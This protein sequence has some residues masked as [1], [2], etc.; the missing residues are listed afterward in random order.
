[1]L[2]LLIAAGL[3]AWGIGI[4]HR[5]YDHD[6]VQRAHS[7]WLASRGLRPYTE[8]FEVHPPYFV[9]LAPILRTW[10][11]PCEAMLALRLFAAAGNLAFLAGLVA[12]GR[13]ATH[14][15]RGDRWAWLGVASVA[16]H[17]R[18][19]DFLVEFRIDGWG[20]ALAAW[21]LVHFLRRPMARYR[22]ATFGAWSCVAT[23]L[24][25]KLA[26]LPPL[27]VAIEILRDRPTTRS[28]LRPG[29]A[30]GLGVGVAGIGFVLFLAAN[31][32]ALDRTYLLLFRY[33]TLSNAHSAFRN[34]LA[35]QIAGAPLLLATIVLGVVAWACTV[36]RR[37]SIADAY[38][39][40]LCLWLSIQALLVAYHY[41]QYYA[42][43]FLFASAF[44]VLLGRSLDALWRPVGALAFAVACGTG[45]VLSIG[46]AQL[47]ERYRPVRGECASIHA[48]N[49]LAAPEDRVVAVPPAHP[50]DRR[51]VFFLWFNTSD[52]AG[53]DSG[54]ILED[55]GPPY[56]PLVSPG[57]NRDALASH[58]PA[59]VIL[60]SGPFAAPYPEGQWQ[61]LIEFLPRHDYRVVRLG[62]LR[63]ALRPDR[64]EKYR[65]TGIFEDAA[66]PLG[67]M[68]P[69]AR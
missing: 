5:N 12:L 16:A 49:V 7:V 62:G 67:P 2:A 64:F 38:H 52:P 22:Y 33:H 50:I 19:L 51:D 41:K 4:V 40:A 54:R 30:Y 27:V 11:D 39:P 58:P 9:L 43:W 57:A 66:G 17:P 60:D 69:R 32:I 37:K 6:E 3:V 31:R 45:L 34:G 48:L 1:M 13:A 15:V 46:I 47:W 10:T 8:F 63:L 23:L 29:V 68:M 28:A 65:G 20:Y 36:A 59:F 61:A 55:L 42:P 56:R 14:G 53:Y 24:C 21:S 44:V 25:P 18:V 26:I 35:R